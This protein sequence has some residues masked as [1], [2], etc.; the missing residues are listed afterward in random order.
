MMRPRDTVTHV[1]L[2]LDIDAS[3]V[4]GL[5][6][7]ATR[8]GTTMSAV[9]EIGLRSILAN[10]GADE[11]QAGDLPPLPSWN[12]GGLLVDISNR[13]ELYRVMAEE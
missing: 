2:T 5:R 1:K 8:R 9:V 11:D 12:S 10:S 3:I 7:E 6:E 4:Q 13:A